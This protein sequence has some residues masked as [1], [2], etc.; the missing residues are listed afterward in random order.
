MARNSS[1]ACA[2]GAFSRT[3][4]ATSTAPRVASC[5]RTRRGPAT[6][7]PPRRGSRCRS[8]LTCCRGRAS[9]TRLLDDAADPD[10]VE[11]RTGLVL[12]APHGL[13]IGRFVLANDALAV[14]RHHGAL[15]VHLVGGETRP[16]PA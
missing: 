5:R 7:S 9:A 6:S 10:A 4:R 12:D 15:P 3:A 14:G 13:G 11:L 8:W 1:F 16:H 2:P